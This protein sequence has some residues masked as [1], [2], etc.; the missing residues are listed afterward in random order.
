[1]YL[2]HM[3]SIIIPIDFSLASENAMHY[4]AQ[5]ATRVNTPVILAHIYQLPISMNDMPVLVVSA[6]E[7]KKSADAGLDRCKKELQQRYPSLTIQTESRLGSIPEESN[8]LAKE[9]DC[10]AMVMGTH[11]MKGLER[12]I[13]GSTTASVIRH[14]H[15]PVLAVPEEFRKFS[16]N[17]LVLA[18]DL[19]AMPDQ[20]SDKII[21]MVQRLNANF[22]IVHVT[23][24]EEGEKPKALLEKLHLL[25]P[26]FQTIS[27]NKV[28]DA[29]KAYI[30]EVDADLLIILPHEHNLTDRLFFKVHTEAIIADMQIPVLAIKT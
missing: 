12:I 8:N 13:F 3:N 21:E 28:K 20:L 4:G 19:E 15:S 2:F 6:D 23:T 7:L 25:S 18:A 24:K 27:G 17:N 11:H 30:Q 1:M 29:L 22:H 10:L 14:A 5:L 16:F 9:E 26:A